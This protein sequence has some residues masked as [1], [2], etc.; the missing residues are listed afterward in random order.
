MLKSCITCSAV[1][2]PDIQLQY[3]DACQSAMY[4]SKAC[5]RED[6]IKQHKQICKFLNVGHGDMQI[7]TKGHTHRWDIL[8]DSF[9]RNDHDLDAG[10]K[11]FFTLFTASTFEGSQAAAKKMKKFAKGQIKNYQKFLFFHSLQFL[12]RSSNNPSKFSWPNSPLLV[13]LQFVDPNARYE[14]DDT[15]LYEGE[16]R[17]TPLHQ[18]A[19]LLDPYNYTTHVNQLIL[20]K[21][22]IQHGANVSTLSIPEGKTA[23]HSACYGCNVTNL[24]FVEFLLKEGADPNAKECR[25]LTPLMVTIPDAPGVAKFLLNWP[26]TDANITT[27]SG[28]SFLARVRYTL[29][30][31]SEVAALPNNPKRAQYEFTLQQ[32]RE[33][34][35]MLVE[36]GALD[37]GIT[38]IE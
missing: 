14:D 11:Q 13:M 37:T 9:E 21:Q 19:D 32:W 38:N 30:K 15:P 16:T 5:Q 20:A 25:G 29:T 23:L 27:R 36:R 18:L 34:E 4:C 35:A 22:L 28:A 17:E 8:K 2:S 3:C 6:W 1:A 7:R 24:D 33:I 10:D 31:Y 12:L 26:S